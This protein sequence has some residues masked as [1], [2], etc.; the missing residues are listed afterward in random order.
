MIRKA[1]DDL[2]EGIII[3]EKL[4]KEIRFADD[5]GVLA[6]TQER[7]QKLMSSLDLVADLY[8]MKIIIK[9]TKAMKVTT[10]VTIQE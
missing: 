1:F 5:K 3:G 10:K 8:G 9:K 2:E 6:S 4:I 7:L